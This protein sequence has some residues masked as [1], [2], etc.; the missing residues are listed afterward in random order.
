MTTDPSSWAGAIFGYNHSVA[1]VDQVLDPAGPAGL[2][3]GRP[4]FVAATEFSDRIG[5]WGDDLSLD[6]ASFAELSPGL[7]PDRVSKQSADLL[8]R[9]P[10]MTA[11]QCSIRPT[12]APWSSTS[13]DIAPDSRSR[14]HSAATTTGSTSPAARRASSA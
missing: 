5:A 3:P 9:L 2:A 13:V 1:Y 7:P 4:A 6:G 8:G 10:Y 12:A 11:P 14:T